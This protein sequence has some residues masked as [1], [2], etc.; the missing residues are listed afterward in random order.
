VTHVDILLSPPPQKRLK[1]CQYSLVEVFYHYDGVNND[2]K[3][4]F[5]G[6]WQCC[7][8]LA[9]ARQSRGFPDIRNLVRHLCKRPAYAFAAIIGPQGFSQL[10]AFLVTSCLHVACLAP[11]DK[12]FQ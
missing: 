7:Q 3:T 5:H 2:G 12:V 9:Q 8:N 1:N 11:G 4:E 6:P 10:L